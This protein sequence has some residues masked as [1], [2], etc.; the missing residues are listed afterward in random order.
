M[1]K[2]LIFAFVIIGFNNLTAQDSSFE[3]TAIMKAEVQLGKDWDFSYSSLPNPINITLKNKKL[4]MIYDSGKVFWDLNINKIIKTKETVE[5][6]KITEKHLALEYK[7]KNGFTGYIIFEYKYDFGEEYY[8]LRT[9][10]IIN[11]WV[12]SYNYYSN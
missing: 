5:N 3:F 6:G 8:T 1:K 10:F 9:P 11:G 7:E 4:L 12:F 2:L